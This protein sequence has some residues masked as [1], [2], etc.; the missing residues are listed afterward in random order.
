MN[1]LIYGATG[2]IGNKLVE[3]LMAQ[4][5]CIGNVSRRISPIAGVNNY[6]FDDDVEIILSKFKPHK[7]IY[8]SAC[9]DNNNI[10]SIIDIN[11][12]KPLEILKVLEINSD[13][14]FI[15]IGS[16]WQ[17]GNIDNKNIA[18]DLYSASKKAIVPFLD[19]YNTYTKVLCKEIVLYGTYGESDG[20]GKLL[21]Y[22]ITMSNKCQKVALTEGLQELNLVNVDDICVNIEKI[23]QITKKNKFQILSDSSYTP[24]ELVEIIRKYQPIEVSFGE[25][26]YR[27]VELMTLWM[28][29]NYTQIYTEDNIESYIKA[30]LTNV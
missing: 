12:K 17:F 24:R 1:I 21:D 4:G 30:K 25:L 14:E 26:D 11:V 10:A 23:M 6:L 22:L 5:Y 8:M 28:N 3:Y 27:S 29:S 16:Y 9:F 13:I 15:Y 18:I 2:Y 20:R 7:I 19:F